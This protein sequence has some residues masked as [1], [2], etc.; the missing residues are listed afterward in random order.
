LRSAPTVS[1][2]PALDT[3]SPGPRGALFMNAARISGETIP[4]VVVSAYQSATTAMFRREV[5]ALMA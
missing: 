4:V 1:S 5:F 2:S 3:D